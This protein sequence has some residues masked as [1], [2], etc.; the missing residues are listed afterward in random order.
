[1][2]GAQAY[3]TSPLKRQEPA[4]STALA[5]E[6]PS[7]PSLASRGVIPL[8]SRSHRKVSTSGRNPE[9]P[10][11]RD[12]TR[13]KMVARAA[14]SENAELASMSPAAPLLGAF[15]G[16]GQKIRR[17][18]KDIMIQ[19]VLDPH[20][21]YDTVSEREMNAA[22][23]EQS[24]SRFSKKAGYMSPM[25]LRQTKLHMCLSALSREGVLIHAQRKWLATM[26]CLARRPHSRTD[27]SGV[28]QSQFAEMVVSCLVRHLPRHTQRC[29]TTRPCAKLSTTQEGND[30]FVC[31]T[32]RCLHPFART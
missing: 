10:F 11:M 30:S 12:T 19:D 9:R 8:F 18:R 15:Q 22:T 21:V 17:E 5:R 29:N 20:L 13:A 6:G 25:L 14:A 26:E 16:T 3:L 7:P 31:F 2:N 28:Q 4:P 32:D 27:G 24:P 23:M 1:M